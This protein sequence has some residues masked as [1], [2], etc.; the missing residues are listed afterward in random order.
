MKAMLQREHSKSRSPMAS[1]CACNIVL[2]KDNQFGVVGEI[3]VVRS[4]VIF[5]GNY[6]LLLSEK[7]F[8]L[9]LLVVLLP[10]GSVFQLIGE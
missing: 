9:P 6:C 5:L 1:L 3:L 4:T 2:L 8:G 10:H 7:S